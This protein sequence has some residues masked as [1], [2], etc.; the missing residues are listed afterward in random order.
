[1]A[2]APLKKRKTQA[3]TLAGLSDMQRMDLEQGHGFFDQYP[4]REAM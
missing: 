1:M 3:D 4:S 2:R